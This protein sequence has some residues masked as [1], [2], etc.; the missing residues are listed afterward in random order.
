MAP[1]CT[2]WTSHTAKNSQAIDCYKSMFIWVSP[3]E[4]PLSNEML[5]EL[6]VLNAFYTNKELFLPRDLRNAL[7]SDKLKKNVKFH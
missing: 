5:N 4:N 3:R 2:T 1:S 7:R 6:L